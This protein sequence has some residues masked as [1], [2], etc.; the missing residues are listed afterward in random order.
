MSVSKSGAA[1]GVARAGS[2]PLPARI[3]AT[4]L[5][6]AHF[7]A[8]LSAELASD[9]ASGPERWLFRRF[10]PYTSLV[11]LDHAHR[12]Y[13]PTPPPTTPIA[14]ARLRFAGDG[15]VQIIRLPDPGARP[16]LRYQRQ[17]ALA[18]HL[19]ADYD[20]EAGE[21]GVEARPVRSWAR[22][23]ARH[24]CRTTPGCTGVTLTIREHGFPPRERLR[25]AA[26]HP[27]APPPDPDAPETYSTPERVGDFSCDGF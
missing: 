16:R 22:S 8:V 4:G 9:P 6:L 11:N 2:W 3:A 26:E 23:Y 19:A 5:L 1:S 25:E 21:S 18:Y 7:V 10:H 12:Y 15:V 27:D 17:L 14:T 24:L 13:A 20:V